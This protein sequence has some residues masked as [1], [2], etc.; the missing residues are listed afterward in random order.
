[1]C[2][3]RCKT[4]ALATDQVSKSSKSQLYWGFCDSILSRSQSIAER[5]MTSLTDDVDVLRE[6]TVPRLV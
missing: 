4:I 1:M 5:F 3:G 2:S 6:C